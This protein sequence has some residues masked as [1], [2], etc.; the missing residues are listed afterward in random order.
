[1]SDKQLFAD[2]DQDLDALI[3]DLEAEDVQ[4]EETNE[5][6]E[7]AGEVRAGSSELPHT[8]A[9][10]GLSSEEVVARRKRFGWNKL[11]E[12]RQNWALKFFAFFVGPIQFVMEVRTWGLSPL[13]GSTDR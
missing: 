11:R 6:K 5:S 1:M 4:T 7:E 10:A 13:D 12:E 8:D 2:E 3:R 9:D